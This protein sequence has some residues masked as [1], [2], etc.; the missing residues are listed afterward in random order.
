MTWLKLVEGYM[1]MQMISELAICIL[2]FSIINYSLKEPVWVCQS[3]GQE[4]LSGHL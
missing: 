2:V 1:P 3:F 4:S